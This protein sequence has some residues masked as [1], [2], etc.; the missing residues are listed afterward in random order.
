M[1]NSYY[2]KIVRILAYLLFVLVFL[3]VSSQ[4]FFK[5]ESDSVLKYFYHKI[6]NFNEQSIQVKESFSLAFPVSTEK[7]FPFNFDFYG[8]QVV[9]NVFDPLIILDKNLRPS[10]SLALSYGLINDNTWNFSIKQ[11]IYFHDGSNLD[12]LDIEKSFELALNSDKLGEYLSSIDKIEKISDFEFNIVTKFSDPL[13]LSKLSFVY[14]VPSEYSE[15]SKMIGSGPFVFDEKIGNEVFLS[16]NANYW[17]DISCFKKLKIIFEEDTSKRI[18]LLLDGV[19]DFLAFV[20]QGS[21]DLIKQYGFNTVSL[22]SLEVQFLLFNFKSPLFKDIKVRQAVASLIDKEEIADKFGNFLT[23]STQFVGSGVF[24]FNPDIQFQKLELSSI[25]EII[26][27]LSGEK[28]I[29]FLLPK[30]L[31]FLGSTIKNQLK[32]GGLIVNLQY[33]EDSEIE[34]SLEKKSADLIFMGFK[35]EFGDSGEFF[36][37]VLKT[38]SK[39]NFFNYSNLEL[40]KLISESE[41]NLDASKRLIQLKNIMKAIIEEDV[42]G[43][44]LFEYDVF[45]GYSKDFSYEPRLD[46]LIYLQDFTQIQ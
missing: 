44:P 46:G 15:N 7:I 19:V 45:Y 2:I 23:V 43:L 38:N 34:E 5:Q 21:V 35:S 42:I 28:R 22:P 20:P 8:R 24:G 17:G 29:N 40:E 4:V 6:F 11:G 33:V 12:F 30:S 1:K 36:D 16:Q 37:L 14:I 41:K 27:K 9:A 31:E 13:L 18:D 3:L 32:D 10:S 25:K 26:S 39:N